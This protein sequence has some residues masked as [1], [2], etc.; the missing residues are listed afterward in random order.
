MGTL[1]TPEP[2]TRHIAG[3]NG[4]NAPEI[5]DALAA[6]GGNADNL[7]RPLAEKAQLYAS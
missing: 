5:T 2:S 4:N 3:T 7:I 6:M 1:N